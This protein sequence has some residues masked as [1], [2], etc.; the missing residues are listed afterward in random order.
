MESVIL[1]IYELGC[2]AIPAFLA[3]VLIRRFRVS[4]ESCGKTPSIALGATFAVYLFALLH[5][6]GAGTIHDVMR[7]GLDLN[8]AQ[9]NLVPFREF[10]EDVG[11]HVLNVILFVPLGVFAHAF[12]CRRPALLPASMMA[13]ATSLAIEISQLLNSR[14]TDID[15][16]LM[17]IIGA[18]VGYAVCRVLPRRGRPDREPRLGIAAAMLAIAFATRFFLY[19][20]MG[21]AKVLF[22]F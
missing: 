14:V 21:L 13:T 2:T 18:L 16:L 12:S 17:N 10:Q 20:E 3:F 22:G 15:D 9:I 7:F 19:D 6:T 5:F 11:G 8:P 1:Y 4:D